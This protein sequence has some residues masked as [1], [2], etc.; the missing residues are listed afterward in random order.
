MHR[1][2]NKQMKKVIFFSALYISIVSNAQVIDGKI[3]NQI[4]HLRQSNVDTF[5]VYSLSCNGGLIPLDTCA[6]ENTQYLFWTKT[7]RTFLMRFD[8]CKDYK[9]IALDS[10]NPIAFYLSCKHKIIKEKI[11]PPTYYEVKKTKQGFEH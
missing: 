6:D 4:N 3:E 11:K 2:R 5:L 8:Y 7:S 1:H 9:A 10:L